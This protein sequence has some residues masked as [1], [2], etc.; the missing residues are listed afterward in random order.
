MVLVW[1][2]AVQ[3]TGLCAG[4]GPDADPALPAGGAAEP[5]PVLRLGAL[6]PPPLPHQV[7]QRARV[8]GLRALLL[9]VPGD[10]HQHQEPPAGES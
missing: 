9:Q 7:D 3:V 1:M 2:V 6:H 10:R 5:V 4:V 8:L